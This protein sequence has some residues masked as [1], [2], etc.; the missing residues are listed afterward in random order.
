MRPYETMIIFDADLD[1]AAIGAVLDR[2]LGVLESNGGRR[3]QIDRWGKRTFAYELH[4]RREG[5]Y[6][7]VEFMAEPAA[8]A[9]LDRFLFLA[10]EVVRHKIM[11]LADEAPASR[12]NSTA[13]P[14]AAATVDSAPAPV[15]EVPAAS[16][17]PVTAAATSV[18]ADAG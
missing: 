2:A 3:G 12:G 16:T 17:P 1:D 5:Y 14:A 13:P 11:R 7:V 6:I 9:E 18:P 4:H 8:A 10:D 15:S